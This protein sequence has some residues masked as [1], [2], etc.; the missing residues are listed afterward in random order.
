MRAW[1]AFF[2]IYLI[3]AIYFSYFWLPELPEQL[4]L[5]EAHVIAS[6]VTDPEALPLLD[7]KTVTLPD[8]DT[9]G[10]LNATSLWYLVSFSTNNVANQKHAVYLPRL[11][12]NAEI[13]L[14]KQ[15]LG[16]GGSMRQP[17]TRN[18]NHN[19]IFN[20]D[21]SLLQQVNTL[22][23][24]LVGEVPQKNYLGD[25]YIGPEQLLKNHA[26]LNKHLHIDLVMVITLCLLFSSIFISILWLLRQSD[27]YYLWYAIFSLLWVFHDYNHFLRNLPI[28]TVLW[29]TLSPIAFG[30]SMLSVILFIH[31]YEG[32]F[33]VKAERSLLTYVGTLTLPFLWQDLDWIMF[34][35]YFIWSPAIALM[36]IY[37]LYFLYDHYARTKQDRLVPIFMG[38]FA[39]IVFGS[40]DLLLALEVLPKQS[41]YMI[42]FAALLVVVVIATTLITRFVQSMNVV[43]HYNRQLQAEV[44][45]N[46]SDMEYSYRQ[47]QKLMRKYTVAEERQRIMR[48]IHDGIGGQLVAILANLDSGKV[49][50][51]QLKADIKYALQ[52]LRMVIDSLDEESDDLPTLLGM[53]RMRLS[54]QFA[55]AKLK[56]HWRVEELPRI[57]NFGP[58]K[59]LNTMRIIQEAIT[60]AIKHS[61]ADNL[62][63]STEL[64]S[65]Q[66]GTQ[67]ACIIVNDDGCGTL[68]TKVTG[69]G[70]LNMQKRADLIGG[71]L[72]IDA[73]INAGVS[74][75]LEIPVSQHL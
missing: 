61:D 71:E 66:D 51:T 44:H 48:D 19:L 1:L 45:R 58:A 57:D 35:A 73:T 55:N 50:Q 36:G 21:S 32:R 41:P 52:D 24:H 60:N 59:V 42:H 4:R 23:I 13:Y 29:E 3:G 6:P 68:P 46:T 17:V 27:T 5:S 72:F 67:Y 43:E 18:R 7:K 31:R 34:Y 70:L 56:L 39:I 8:W 22:A 25:V 28:P 38:G 15:W 65:K 33:S 40:H 53:L 62:T 47:V 30:Y 9:P 11:S 37:A 16:N 63:I 12:Q 26:S 2:F 49:A 75:R 74:V 69:R 20:F 64:I 10:Q 54:D 14:N